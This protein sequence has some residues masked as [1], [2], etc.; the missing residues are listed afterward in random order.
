M[1]SSGPPT[2]GIAKCG[3][4]GSYSYSLRGGYAQAGNCPIHFVSRGNAAR[5]CNWLQNGQ[6]TGPEEP[7]TTETAAYTLSGGTP[8]SA[9]MSATR[10]ASA[11]YLISSENE[12]HEV[13][14]DESGGAKAGCWAY[15]ARSNDAALRPGLLGSRRSNHFTQCRATALLFIAR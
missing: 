9:L 5:F 11:T 15:P 3:S 2:F 14:Y 8:D 10:N 13:T 1:G 12:R 4:P 6:P 7:G